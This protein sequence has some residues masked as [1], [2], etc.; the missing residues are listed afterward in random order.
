MSSITVRIPP[1]AHE[2]A[3]RIAAEETTTMSAV[4]DTALEH[5]ERER[6]LAAYNESIARLKADHEAWADYQTEIAS[7]DSTAFDGLADYPYEGIE[8]L[9]AAV[10]ASTDE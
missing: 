6:M 9:M 10:E 5:Y 4:I 3:Q 7:L 1:S 2:R 8:E